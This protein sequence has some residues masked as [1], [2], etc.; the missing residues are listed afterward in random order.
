MKRASS[1]NV[2]ILFNVIA[3][4]AVIVHAQNKYDNY[5]KVQYASPLKSLTIFDK[6]QISPRDEVYLKALKEAEKLKKD[7]QNLV[8]DEDEEED[9]EKIGAMDAQALQSAK[10]KSSNEYQFVGIVNGAKNLKEVQ[11]FA[12]RKRKVGG[13]QD[14]QDDDWSLRMVY[15][16]PLSTARDM[17]VENKIDLYAEYNPDGRDPETGRVR[18]KPTY[19]LRKKSILNAFNFAPKQ[20]LTD[21]SGMKTRERRIKPGLYTDGESVY[22]GTYDYRK[23]KNVM[24]KYNSPMASSDLKEYLKTNMGDG[25][26]E[27]LMS[28]IAEEQPDIVIE[29]TSAKD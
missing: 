2:A 18:I 11:W 27:K 3:A 25:Q 22:E 12:K 24:R 28:R 26:V 19:S 20:F 14:S 6:P 21:K 29:R 16:D 7:K 13:E 9:G 15:V 4:L 17:L 8:I 5:G 23:G 1:K 10:A